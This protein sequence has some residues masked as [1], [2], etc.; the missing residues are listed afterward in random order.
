[1]IQN[2]RN[3]I[4]NNRGEMILSAVLVIGLMMLGFFISYTALITYIK[5]DINNAIVFACESAVKN[6]VVDSNNIK[7]IDRTLATQDFYEILQLNMGLTSSNNP[8]GITNNYISSQVKIIQITYY[9]NN[10]V[11]LPYSPSYTSRIYNYPTIHV[12]IEVPIFLS[13][14]SSVGFG[15]LYPTFEVDV[16]AEDL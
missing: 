9:D 15:T 12:V 8:T 7:T 10:S 3:L 14:F 16:A 2:F 4:F 1:M 6:T 5:K 11:S 13:F